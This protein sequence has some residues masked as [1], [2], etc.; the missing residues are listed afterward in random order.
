MCD[1]DDGQRAPLSFEQFIDLLQRPPFEPC[2]SELDYLTPAE[3]D[4]AF[5]EIMHLYRRR[6]THYIARITEDR[7]GAPD[8][9]QEV[10]FNVYKARSSFELSYIYR[11]A[12]NAAYNELRRQAQQ[13]R[14]SYILWTDMTRRSRHVG[15]RKLDPPSERSVHDEEYLRQTRQEALRRALEILPEKFRTALLLYAE[16]KTY[17]QISELTETHVETARS[18]VCRGKSILRGKL[19]AYL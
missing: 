8:I 16:G 12:K 6:I 2:D 1:H 7:D 19:K 18:R 9:A 4:D 10:F 11:A 5:A 3:Y 13:R 17:R 14:V 15:V